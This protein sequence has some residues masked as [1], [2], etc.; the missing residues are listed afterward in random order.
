MDRHSSWRM[1]QTLK[2]LS[3]FCTGP[4]PQSAAA[5]RTCRPEPCNFP[6][7]E[8]PSLASM[9]RKDTPSK[10]VQTAHSPEKGPSGMCA[11]FV[12]SP[13]SCSARTSSQ[14]PKHSPRTKTS[15]PR[16]APGGLG[17][18]PGC[19]AKVPE[20]LCERRS[21]PQRHPGRRSRRSGPRTP[22]HGRLHGCAFLA[23]GYWMLDFDPNSQPLPEA[24][25][26][27]PPRTCCQLPSMHPLPHKHHFSCA[28]SKH[29]S[30]QSVTVQ[31]R[32]CQTPTA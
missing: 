15:E 3:R 4:Q 30:S 19:A 13:S 14:P 28:H 7:K 24:H 12:S 18:R 9:G 22:E 27:P 25:P 5:G 16:P 6:A 17:Q 23:Q 29:P 8:M 1:A 20:A 21:F 26:A 32:D 2:L 31:N 11:A 10:I